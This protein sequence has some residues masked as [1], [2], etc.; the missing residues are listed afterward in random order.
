MDVILLNL[1]LKYF[2]K[3]MSYYLEQNKFHANADNLGKI[4]CIA[5]I[6]NY[7]KKLAEFIAY[8]K[9]KNILDFENILKILLHEINNYKI[10]ALKIFI[11]KCLFIIENKNYLEFIDSI[12]NRNDLQKLLNHDDFIELSVDDFEKNKEVNSIVNSIGN[13]TVKLFYNILINKYILDLYGKEEN[14]EELNRNANIVFNKFNKLF[15]LHENSQLILNYLINKNLFSQKI[16]PKLKLQNLSSEQFYILL[17]CIKTVITLQLCENN[18]FSLFYT[19]KSNKNNLIQF[20]N[21][22]YIPGAYP[23]QNE[24]VE[25]YYEIVNHLNSQPSDNA[26]YICSCGKY[27]TI[28]PCGFPV[29]VSRCVKCNLEIGGRRHRLVRR[30]N[31]Y[32][33]YLN[34][35]ARAKEIRKTFADRNMPYK[36][37]DQFKREIID[38]ILNTPN[39][40]LGKIT[41]EIINKTGNNIRNIN[42]LTIR[43]LN[44]VLC[45]HLIIANILEILDDNEISGFFSEE[46]SC[47]GII[48]DNW[49]KI[50]ELINNKGINNIQTYMNII[51]AKIIDI[52][53]N[54]NIKDINSPQGREIIENQVNEYINHNN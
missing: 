1:S 9:N 8:N 41:R 36:N 51:L 27:Y 49:K 43:L 12:K 22:N 23:I 11:F 2:K 37:L 7:L 38:P 10:F 18:I 19:D 28:L 35:E 29:L 48:L 24:F 46:T 6:K 5:Y 15:Q 17:I 32:R 16:L 44:F 14:N 30:P 4:Y 33:I 39:K 54:F 20:L 3:A 47:F 50:N 25:S 42:E 26:I 21:D 13:K 40:G 52:I 34:E 31:H 45:S 53:G